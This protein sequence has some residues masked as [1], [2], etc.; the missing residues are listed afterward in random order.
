MERKKY[1]KCN[2]GECMFEP[3]KETSGTIAR[4]IFYYFLMYMYNPMSRPHTE[5]NPWLIYDKKYGKCFPTNFEKWKVFFF[6][7][8][9]YFY[10]SAKTY[11]AT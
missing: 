7:N 8:F 2:I 10:F 3:K 4:I 11:S 5:E 1:K 6:N 9:Y